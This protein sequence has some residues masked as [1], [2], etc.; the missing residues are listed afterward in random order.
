MFGIVQSW[1][2]DE[3]IQ[4]IVGAVFKNNGGPIFLL[5]WQVN[6]G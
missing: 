5:P 1:G 4:E 6:L 3:L 2:L